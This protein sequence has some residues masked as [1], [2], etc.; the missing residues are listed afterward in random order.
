[1]AL[2][3]PRGALLRRTLA[4]ALVPVLLGGL[5]GTAGAI[6]TAR[7]AAALLFEVSPLDT[8]SI[9][10]GAIILTAVAVLAAAGPARRAARVD[11]LV[12]LRA[13]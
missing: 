3:A 4:A 8:I 9:L 6:A 7:A 12:A 5:A 13:E 2:G 1:V 11:P 10:A